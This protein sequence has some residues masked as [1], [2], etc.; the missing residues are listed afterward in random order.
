M[1]FTSNSLELIRR[2]FQR[3]QVIAPV[4]GVGG[5]VQDMNFA[6]MSQL[7][8]GSAVGPLGSSS[9]WLQNSSSIEEDL[10]SKYQDYEQMDQYPEINATLDLFADDATVQNVLTGKSLW[11][12]APDE[13]I[14]DMMNE[15]LD[16]Q[17]R[18]EEDLWN[19][20]RDTCK[21]GNC[22]TEI[23]AVD[24]KGVMELK[25]LPTTQV[26][27]VQDRLGFC[28]GFIFDPMCGF[29][30][31]T[32]GFQNRLKARSVNPIKDLLSINS[33]DLVQ[34]YEPW[35]MV[36]F[37]MK[38]N[39]PQDPYGNAVIEGARY[40]WR[41]LTM[42]EDAMIVYKLTR[43]PQRYAF[44]V[45]VGDV[46]PREAKKLLNDVKNE[47]KKTKYIDE[48]GKISFRY[49][50]LSQDEDIFLAVR[51]EKR[52]TEVEV[53]SGPEGQQIDD[54]NYF[55]E[56]LLASL[57][58]PKSYLGGDDTVGRANLAQLD[59]RWA[60]SIMR[61][62]RVMKN[63][64]EHVGRVE[65]SARNIDPDLVEF[66]PM[67]NIPSGV[68]EL[69]QLEVQNAKLD[70]ADRYQ[71]A[72]FSEYYIWSNIL[73]MADEDIEKIQSQRA[74][75]Q[76]Q[77]AG[78]DGGDMGESIRRN[79]DRDINKARDR[80]IKNHI[81]E[82]TNK[83]QD[84]LAEGRSQFSKKMNQLKMLT[85]EIKQSMPNRYKGKKR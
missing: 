39:S 20:T 15:M 40:A 34:V 43:S 13:S 30:V 66:V 53:L 12:E 57:K 25:Q 33:S 44:Y 64:F 37:K 54:V 32:Q 22:Y 68:L 24:R 36:H 52:S 62:Q 58:V 17:I 41:R 84:E 1:S 83:I 73:G 2:V 4:P 3:D 42:M 69:A 47:F 14:Q 70:L 48:S 49:N 59:V 8:A 9:E 6:T 55:R 19:L 27:R 46:P 80:D 74:I 11:Y 72:N 81:S 50:P 78:G 31:D 7:G 16:K 75:E 28:Y 82:H 71:R 56:K 79:I 63:G 10:V 85:Q 18:I 21:Y 5:Y 51:K 23:I 35:E 29:M 67:M 38:G 76:A 61:V 45:D 26:R 65:L 77:A 60:R